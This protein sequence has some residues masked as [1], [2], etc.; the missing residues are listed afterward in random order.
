MRAGALMIDGG[1]LRDGCPT[2]KTAEQILE[3]KLG[4]VDREV[5][6][7]LVQVGVCLH[8]DRKN[9]EAEAAFRRALAINEKA[10]GPNDRAGALL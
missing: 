2:V 8:C 6:G 9:D 1:N 10:F 4:P 7:A 5:A 3:K